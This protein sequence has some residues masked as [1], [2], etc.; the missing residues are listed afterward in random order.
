MTV[1]GRD[2]GVNCGSVSVL[3]A[4]METNVLKMAL[5]LIVFLSLI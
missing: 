1:C 3:C 2:S 4:V 5:G